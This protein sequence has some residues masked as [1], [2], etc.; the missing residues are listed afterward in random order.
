V[1]YFKWYRQE[2]FTGLAYLR[3]P[4]LSNKKF[5][6]A[7]AFIHSFP[8][9]QSS[10]LDWRGTNYISNSWQAASHFPLFDEKDSI[11][12]KT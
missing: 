1:E 11:Y 10:R 4:Y 12:L 8:T 2:P 6:P 9:E 3:Q 7:N 5:G